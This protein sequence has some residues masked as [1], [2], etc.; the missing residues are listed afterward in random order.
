MQEAE[1]SGKYPP[2]FC[3]T[4]IKNSGNTSIDLRSEYTVFKKLNDEEIMIR[5]FV[6]F[7]NSE[8]TVKTIHMLFILYT[9]LFAFFLLILSLYLKNAEF[10]LTKFRCNMGLHSS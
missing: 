10:H 1:K 9:T 2:R 8:G 5:K 4:Y 3:I 6:L 7:E